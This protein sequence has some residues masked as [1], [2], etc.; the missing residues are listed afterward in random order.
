LCVVAVLEAKKLFRLAW[1]CLK[2]HFL[3]SV[4]AK[5]LRELG[6]PPVFPSFFWALCVFR[7]FFWVLA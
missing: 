7:A 6:G 2:F 4:Y 5:T 1:V 3:A